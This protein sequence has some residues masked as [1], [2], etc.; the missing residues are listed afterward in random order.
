MLHQV[1]D[2]DGGRAGHTGLAVD[3]KAFSTLMSF[4]CGIE[5]QA[6]RGRKRGGG[7]GRSVFPS[8]QEEW[9]Q[10]ILQHNIPVGSTCSSNGLQKLTISRNVGLHFLKL[11]KKNWGDTH[12]TVCM[13]KS[14]DNLGEPVFSFHCESEDGTQDVTLGSKLRYPLNYLINLLFFFE[15]CACVACGGR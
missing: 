3:E 13:G 2:D 15:V 10:T 4:L 6:V 7:R 1:G 8:V 14:K 11:L 9:I 5:R 12:A